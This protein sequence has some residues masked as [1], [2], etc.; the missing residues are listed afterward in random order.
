M[1]LGTPRRSAG[2]AVPVDR[3]G[4]GRPPRTALGLRVRSVRGARRSRYER[5]LEEHSTGP[6]GL[7]GRLAVASR[8][9]RR[10]VPAQGPVE[11]VLRDVA[12]GVAA[13][14]LVGFLLWVLQRAVALGVGRVCFVARDGQVLADVSERLIAR[15]GLDLEVR[16]LHGSRQ[17]WLL[18]TM[19]E[20]TP[21]ATAWLTPG[22]DVHHLSL[23]LLLARVGVTCQE[24]ADEL[25]R[26][27]WSDAVWDS[28]VPP[29]E[30]RATL[31][32]LLALPDLRR[33]VEQRAAEQHGL[34]V[35]YLAQQDLLDG[36]PM[37]LVDLA[38]GGT[39][40]AALTSVLRAAGQEEPTSLILGQRRTSLIPAGARLESWFP[41]EALQTTPQL[42]DG[43][44]PALE[45][46]CLAD[47]GTVLGYVDDDGS[48]QPVLAPGGGDGPRQWGQPLVRR[49][50]GHVAARLELDRGD[51][52]VDLRPVLTALFAV[53]WRSPTLPEARAWGEASLEDGWGEHAVPVTVAS[54]YTWTGSLAG[55]RREDAGR[56]RAVRT[57]RHGSL[58]LTPPL[59]RGVLRAG[60]SARDRLRSTP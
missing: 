8:R 6:D 25:A 24:V 7:T 19:R 50:V 37:A 41:P 52:A 59:L 31:R 18:P 33:L 39:L 54:A 2:A 12:A 21:E 51:L 44:V 36:T 32:R 3:D 26:A 22:A 10:E 20:A 1:P 15:L 48:A 29:A 17:A 30:R 40:H 23:R 4:E 28:N 16:Y 14:L 56:D 45:L 9:A 5:L 58:T 46:F 47:H 55:L 43:L 42:P 38:T 34:L 57:W 11:V 27:G 49:T 60:Y 35:R 13:P 53:F